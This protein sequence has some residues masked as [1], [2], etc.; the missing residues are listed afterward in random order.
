MSI[1]INDIKVKIGTFAPSVTVDGLVLT[2]EASSFSR[3]PDH[4]S[5][6]RSSITFTSAD[7]GKFIY[8]IL[9]K[10]NGQYLYDLTVQDPAVLSPMGAQVEG[11]EI[12]AFLSG[13]V[14]EDGFDLELRHYSESGS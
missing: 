9:V 2:V 5:I 7:V 6:A 13:R 3:E 1:R 10:R 11:E 8:A 12:F 14:L 4:G